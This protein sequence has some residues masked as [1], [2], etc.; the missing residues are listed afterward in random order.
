MEKKIYDVLVVGAGPIGS[1]TAYQLAELGFEVVLIEE[2]DEVGKDV[3]C[4][5]V[6]GTEAFHR[7]NLPKKSIISE[8]KS[9]TFFSPSFI[10][11]D[12][13]PS[14]TL[15][16]VVDRKLFDKD[17][18]EQAKKKGVDVHRGEKVY[19]VN[20]H[21]NFVEAESGSKDYRKKVRAKAVVIATGINYQL[22]RSLGL[23]LPGHFIQGVQAEVEVEGL[24]GTEI[25]V[26][27]RVSPGAFAWAV[28]LGNGWARMGVLA[29]SKGVSRLEGFLKERFVGRIEQKSPRIFQKRIA[30]GAA[31]RSVR[32]RVLTVGEAAGQVKTT[33]GGGIFYGLLCS[34]IAVHILQEGFSRGDLS[35]RQLVQYDRLWKSKLGKELRMGLWMRKA[36]KRLTDKQIDK[37]FKFIREKV[38]V[39]EMLERKVKFDYHTGVISLG[40]RF[41]RGLI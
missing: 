2:H 17:I 19:Q 28:P 24:S 3:V 11:V 8:I 20:A 25:Y 35:E 33:T 31:E 6:I 29:E 26:G 37:I 39:R 38:P 27:K 32:N 14:S 7:F 5:G 30:C 22:H 10:A 9:M 4:T 36:M 18:L 13:A 1:Y 16:Y 12:Y 21:Q 40:L 41:L 34:E 15:A 23:S